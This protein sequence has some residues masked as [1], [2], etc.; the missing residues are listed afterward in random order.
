MTLQEAIFKRTSRRKYDGKPLNADIVKLL[1]KKIESLNAESGLYIQLAIGKTDAFRSLLK[2]YGLFTGVA[3]Y[4]G[5]IGKINDPN[6]EE[7]VGYFGELLVLEATTLGLDTCFVGGSYDKNRCDLDVPD[8]FQLVLTIA[9]GHAPQDQS[10]REKVIRSFVHRQSKSVE[11][12]YTT[13]GIAPDWFHEGMKGVA[14]APSAINR[15]PILLHFDNNEV[16]AHIKHPGP[17]THI[18]LGIAK[19]NFTVSSGVGSW[20]YGDGGKLI[21]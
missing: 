15:Q 4:I 6:L 1:S 14:V 12:L 10:L 19:A 11:E 18:D 3:N 17:F 9:I 16:T 2:T 7:K 13:V 20:K 21:H 8:E 5:M